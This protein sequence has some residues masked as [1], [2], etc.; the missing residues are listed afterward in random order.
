MSKFWLRFLFV[1]NGLTFV[2]SEY[3]W[4]WS[5]SSAL[6][7]LFQSV[8]WPGSRTLQMECRWWRPAAKECCCPRKSVRVKQV[9]GRSKG[10]E[11]GRKRQQSNKWNKHVE[12]QKL[13]KI[14]LDCNG[15]DRILALE[16]GGIDFYDPGALPHIWK[17][18]MSQ[19]LE[20]RLRDCSDRCRKFWGL[21][22]WCSY[23]YT[24]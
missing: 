15:S 2:K 3:Y 16:R 14:S 22:S 1:L 8:I 19:G 11:E 10:R 21:K 4:A 20:C 5:D 12:R 17:S 9:D 13:S 18:S 23:T 7:F 6:W 24:Q